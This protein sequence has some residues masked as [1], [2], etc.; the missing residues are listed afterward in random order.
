L[1]GK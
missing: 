1:E